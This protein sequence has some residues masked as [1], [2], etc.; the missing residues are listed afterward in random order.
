MATSADGARI[1]WYRY[2][3]GERTT[4]FVPT[5][6]LV[7]ARVVGHQVAA[8]ESHTNVLTYD[9]RGAGAS[10]RPKRGYDFP[11]HAAD[12]LAVLDANGIER[13]ALVTASRGLNTAVLLTTSD[14]QRFDRI[15]VVGPYMNLE[16]APPS[17]D[18]ERLEALRNDWRGFIVPFMHAVFT[19]PDSADVI[20][21]MI[22]IGLEATPDVIATQET[23]LDW[24]RPARLLG[25]V[26]CSTLVV[27]GEA[28][29]PVPVALAERIVAAMPN[30][31]LEL[32]PGGGHRPDIRTPELVNP[33]LLDFLLGG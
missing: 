8:L 29:A 32:I 15:A 9:P 10:E 17:P 19:E 13:A 11:H 27:H 7:D 23:E 26:T 24:R 5:W 16:P 21:E 22:A 33:L 14:P 2:G 3:G 20:A 25:S 30:A 18:P 12:A 6:N 4:L 31:R 28:D 1:A